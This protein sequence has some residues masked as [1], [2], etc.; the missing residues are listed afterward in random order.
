MPQNALAHSSSPYLRQHAHH[1]VDWLPW[2]D[3]ALAK[4]KEENKLVIVSIGY[5]TCH[6]CHVMAHGVFEDEATA[7]LQNRGFVSIKV[8]REDR[9][10]LDAYYMEACRL[11]SGQGG[12]PLNA[13][14]LPDGRPVHALTYLPKESWVQLLGQVRMLWIEQPERL[15]AQAE[16]VEQGLTPEPVL[17]IPL[18]REPLRR[19]LESIFRETWSRLKPHLDPA[20]GTLGAP[21]FPLLPFVNSWFEITQLL[22]SLDVDSVPEWLAEAEEHLQI[23]CRVMALGGIHDQVGGGLFRY[24]TDDHWHIPHFEKMLYDNSQ[25]I[26]VLTQTQNPAPKPLFKRSLLQSLH[27]LQEEMRLPNGLYATAYDADS[28]GREGAFYAWT[29][30]DVFDASPNSPWV[31]KLLQT[32]DITRLG[33]WEDGL[34]VPQI[35]A[36]MQKLDDA[37]LLQELLPLEE[38]RQELATWRAQ[39]PKPFLDDKVLLEWNALTARHVLFAAITL[40]DQ[41][42]ASQTLQTLDQLWLDFQD[43]KGQWIHSKREGQGSGFA[44]LTD[45]S[46][47]A[48]AFFEAHQF[49]MNSLWLERA[50]MLMEYGIAHFSQADHPLFAF[51]DSRM[52]AR[53]VRPEME[54]NVTPSGNSTF[55]LML[56]RMG[57]LLHR[58]DWCDLSLHSLQFARETAL[59]HP[60]FHSQWLLAFARVHTPMPVLTLHGPDAQRMAQRIHLLVPQCVLQKGSAKEEGIEICVGTQCLAQKLPFKEALNTVSKVLRSKRL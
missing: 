28:E 52:D 3:E 57:T 8:D 2:G 43:E 29:Q 6:W 5:S 15:I 19:S 35:P 11:I 26:G 56:W 38:A 7:A 31:E 30:A 40:D 44:Y 4:A 49:T 17:E 23:T 50:T 25:W 10:D 46:L 13:I 27:W 51:A 55:C 37:L 20:G 14:C 33:N 60:L 48:Q 1:P 22:R 45:V 58:D 53:T 59:N 34:S 9:P 12:W 21:K 32:L 36:R 47:L 18:S 24:S 39:R 42:L 41:R 54:D 16:A